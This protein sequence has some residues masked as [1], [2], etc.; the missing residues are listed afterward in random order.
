M[1]I[2]MLNLKTFNIID[3]K[4]SE[5]DYRFL[6]ETAISPPSYC[7]KCGTVQTYTSMVKN[8]SCFLTYQCTQNV[9]VFL[10]NVNDI[11]VGNVM[12]LF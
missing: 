12:K 4:K 7:L 6:V 2:N 5:D 3:M 9:K 10:S 11:S 8:N 1:T